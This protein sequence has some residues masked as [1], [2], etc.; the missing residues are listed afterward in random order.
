MGAGSYFDAVANELPL[1]VSGTLSSIWSPEVIVPPTIPGIFVTGFLNAVSCSDVLCSAVGIY[2]DTSPTTQLFVLMRSG[3]G[4]VWS[5]P[6]NFQ[7]PS[8]YVSATGVGLRNGMRAANCVGASCVLVGS[9]VD[10]NVV[11]QPIILFGNTASISKVNENPAGFDSSGML[12]GTSTINNTASLPLL[13][14]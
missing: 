2:T 6:T 1:I 11:Q 7:Y 5:K 8:D 13:P 4:G 10:T 12:V 3:T 9:Y 14:A